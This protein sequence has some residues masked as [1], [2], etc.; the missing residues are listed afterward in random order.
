MYI[1]R[2]EGLGQVSAPI[3]LR[4]AIER[5]RFYSIK[6]GWFAYFDRINPLLGF[7]NYSPIEEDFALAVASWQYQHKL[8]ADGIIGPKTWKKMQVAIGL[9]STSSKPKSSYQPGWVRKLRPLLDRYRDD[10]SLSLLLGW[11]AVESGGRI[12]RT[13]K[14]D[15]RGYFQLHPGESKDLKLNHKRLSTDSD[16]SIKGGIRLIQYYA[17]RAKALGFNPDSHL[18]WRLVKFLHSMGQGAVKLFLD[19]MRQQGID[20]TISSWE[21]FK[22]YAAKNR[23][24]IIRRIQQKYRKT[25]DPVKWIRNVDKVF[26]RGQKL[27]TDS[28]HKDVKEPKTSRSEQQELFLERVL[29][30]HIARSSRNGKRPGLPDLSKSQLD[31][32]KGTTIQMRK[33]AAIAAGQLLT[34]ANNALDLAKT[35]GNK[36]ALRT[37]RI[38]G[39]SG[40]RSRSHQ[41]SLWRKYFR[42]KY[43]PATRS[44][45]TKLSGGEHGSNAVYYMVKYISPKVAAPG[46]SKHQAG[47]AIDFKQIRTKRNRI[48]NSTNSKSVKKW[49]K[50][51]FFNWLTKN[52]KSFGFYPYYKEPWHWIYKP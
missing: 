20:P 39:I 25:I 31:K 48:S 16:Y 21:I 28:K 49:K 12:D 32:V 35:A 42:Q 13:T 15:E 19:D 47:L 52:A 24:R 23:Q 50:T 26:E 9:Q 44:Y 41:E 8:E 34:A 27:V 6:L 2:F 40:Y 22:T 4:R 51:W 38:I 18:F 36:D 30:S 43:Y 10:I 29:A 33:D 3:N 1:N 11:I 7:S 14:L 46:F 37:K 17:K 45:R 5:N